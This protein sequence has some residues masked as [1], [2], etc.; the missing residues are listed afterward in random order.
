MW[1]T[2]SSWW[3]TS[4]GCAECCFKHSLSE[5]LIICGLCLLEIYIN[6]VWE[7][8]SA[9]TNGHHQAGL[10]PAYTKD[11][12][13]AV[14]IILRRRRRRPLRR[15]KLWVRAWLD[16]DRRLMHGH[17]RVSYA[18]DWAAICGPCQLFQLP[19]NVNKPRSAQ[20]ELSERTVHTQC[21]RRGNSMHALKAL[22]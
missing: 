19:P 4:C 9:I 16:V 21:A 12:A 20:W 22:W 18:T 5:V 2:E 14:D 3:S 11:G 8:L 7:I 13:D 15:S 17:Y 1:W 10:L 6:L